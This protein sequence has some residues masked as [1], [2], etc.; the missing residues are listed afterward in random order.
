MSL[1]LKLKHPVQQRHTFENE[2]KNTYRNK[3]Y[4]S[5]N[6]SLRALLYNMQKSLKTQQQENQQSK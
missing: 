1:F 5:P 4:S 3:N 2:N 6:V